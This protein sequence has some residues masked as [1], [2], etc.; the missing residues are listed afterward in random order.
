MVSGPVVF[1]RADEP[2]MSD[3]SLDEFLQNEDEKIHG[4]AGQ[5]DATGDG[6]ADSLF[7]GEEFGEAL[8]HDKHDRKC[9]DGNT[10]D[11]ELP[12]I[13]IKNEKTSL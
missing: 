5:C 12:G 4:K 2:E 1:L 10:E 13:S 7:P 8:E 6:I 3:Y 9:T 11:F